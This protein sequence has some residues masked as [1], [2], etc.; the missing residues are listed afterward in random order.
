M[1]TI[2]RR[3]L[4]STTTKATAARTATASATTTR[5]PVKPNA[6]ASIAP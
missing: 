1:R 4:D 6:P 3:T 5:G 2:G